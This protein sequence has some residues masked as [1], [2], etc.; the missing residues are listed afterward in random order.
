MHKVWFVRHGE[1]I[2][3]A[4]LKTECPISITLTDIGHEQAKKVADQVIEKPSQIILSKHVRTHQTA[5]PTI[6]KFPDVPVEVWDVQEFVYL[7]LSKW[8]GTTK[9]ERRP[10]AEEYWTRYD[11][12]YNDGEG[13]ESFFDLLERV[14]DTLDTL[15]TSSNE[16]TVVFSHGRFIRLMCLLLS[17]PSLTT[18]EY[19]EHLYHKKPYRTVQNGEIIELK[20]TD[21]EFIFDF[22][23]LKNTGNDQEEELD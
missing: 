20:I 5:A 21:N 7:N 3:N 2:G 1:S 23:F 9:A 18:R 22:G 13:A 15:K 10:M 12:E 17:K 14:K 16:F 4:G 8:K 11:P 6:A 19:L